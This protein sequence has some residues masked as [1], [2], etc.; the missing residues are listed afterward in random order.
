MPYLQFSLSISVAFVSML[1]KIYL[2][3]HPN[4]HWICSDF[5]ENE[6]LLKIAHICLHNL[7]ICN[8]LSEIK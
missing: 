7:Q 3:M 2:N 4:S 6:V 5:L 8:F 1:M